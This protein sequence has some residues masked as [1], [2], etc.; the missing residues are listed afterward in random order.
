MGAKYREPMRLRRTGRQCC[1]RPFADD[2]H[3]VRALE[4]ARER[5]AQRAGRNHAAVADAAPAVDHQDC[6]ILDER[7]V[8]EAVVHHDDAR[9]QRRG[10]LGAADAVAGG[11]CVDEAFG[12]A[13][14]ADLM[15]YWPGDQPSPA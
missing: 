7:R 11:D 3:R 2:H 5:R 8:L 6:D 13:R 12:S 14:C 4:L 9:A 1:A 15:E 10:R